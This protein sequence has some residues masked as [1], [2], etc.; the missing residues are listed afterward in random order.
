MKNYILR[1]AAVLSLAMGLAI[2][3]YAGDTFVYSPEIQAQVTENARDFLAANWRQTDGAFRFGEPAGPGIFRNDWA[4]YSYTVPDICS[5]DYGKEAYDRVFYSESDAV[6]DMGTATDLIVVSQDTTEEA[7]DPEVR[8]DD[9]FLFKVLFSD[10][11]EQGPARDPEEFARRLMQQASGSS[12]IPA[13]AEKDSV[14]ISGVSFLHYRMDYGDIMQQIYRE[15]FG[16]D[17]KEHPAY[18]ETYRYALDLYL[19]QVDDKLVTFYAM[20]SGKYYGKTA[21]LLAP[22]RMLRQ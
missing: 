10:M 9:V 14:N 5:Y 17:G 12:R 13:Y 1:T 15:E 11:G 20:T 18:E 4:G 3:A 22:L 6:Y 19:R 7:P 16:N 21:E 8:E 2:P